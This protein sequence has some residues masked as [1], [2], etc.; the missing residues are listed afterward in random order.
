MYRSPTGHLCFQDCVASGRYNGRFPSQNRPR[1]ARTISEQS[2]RLGRARKDKSE[3]ASRDD[4][5]AV[6]T[7]G[8]VRQPD[9]GTRGPTSGPTPQGKFIKEAASNTNRLQSRPGRNFTGND[10]EFLAGRLRAHLD[11]G[12]TVRR[13]KPPRPIVSSLWR[14]VGSVKERNTDRHV[15]A[16]S[17]FSREKP[18]SKQWKRWPSRREVLGP[19]AQPEAGKARASPKAARLLKCPPFARTELEKSP[20]ILKR[21]AWQKPPKKSPKQTIG[22][23]RTASRY[24]FGRRMPVKSISPPP[25]VRAR[26]ER[27][28]G[29]DVSCAPAVCQSSSCRLRM[30]RDQRA[31]L[32][33]PAGSIF[34]Y[35]RSALPPTVSVRWRIRAGQRPINPFG[36]EGGK[37][38]CSIATRQGRRC[39]AL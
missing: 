19:T 10:S 21:P 27:V 13:V 1:A 35:E 3:Q 32:L 25:A 26:H 39:Q 14:R 7:M 34:G 23:A 36:G 24:T 16:S 17:T 22:P 29:E 33:D 30:K 4:V 28:A 9:G 12:R 37:R 38:A 18:N 20:E 6:F 5:R 31:T 2:A 11:Q 15:A 8:L